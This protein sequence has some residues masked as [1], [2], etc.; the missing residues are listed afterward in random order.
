MNTHVIWKFPIRNSFERQLIEMPEGS[1]IV[2]VAMQGEDV[3]VWARCDNRA[4]KVARK[5]YVVATGESFPADLTYIGTCFQ[6]PFVWHV[7]EDHKPLTD[8][9][10]V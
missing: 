6:G 3:T 2:Q 9:V 4:P 1:E 10:S 7:I 5:F 8:P